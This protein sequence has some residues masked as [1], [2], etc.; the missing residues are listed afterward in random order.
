MKRC[1]NIP[2]HQGDITSHLSEWISS[3]RPQIKNYWHECGEKTVPVH[4]WCNHWA[5]CHQLSHKIHFLSQVTIKS[6]NSLLYRIRGNFKK[7]IFGFEVSSYGTHLLNIFTFPICF[8]CQTPIEQLMLNSSAISPIFVRGSA[9]M[10]LS[11]GSCQLLL[12]ED[13]DTVLL[14]FKVPVCSAKFLEPP[15][16]YM[17]SVRGKCI[18]DV[19]NCLCCFTTHFELE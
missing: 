1:W 17:L 9:L 5:G 12:A 18:A 13:V 11:V 4:W 16:H 6:R 3:K 19:A 15:L 14:I 2:K 8:K 7:T 10:I